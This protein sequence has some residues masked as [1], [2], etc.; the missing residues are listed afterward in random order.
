MRRYGTNNF[1]SIQMV[2]ASK[3]ILLSLATKVTLQYTKRIYKV[4]DFALE[5]SNLP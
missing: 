2:M 4:F 5:I 1:T 3:S